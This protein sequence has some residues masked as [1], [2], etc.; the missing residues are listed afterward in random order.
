MPH[1]LEAKII[2]KT[3]ERIQIEITRDNFEAF[4]GAIGLYR[5]EFLQSLDASE[6][7]HHAGRTTKRKSLR[8]LID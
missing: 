6:R 2:K 1:A 3:S 5:S 8:E 4:C 7:D